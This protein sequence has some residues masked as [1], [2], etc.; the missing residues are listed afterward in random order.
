MTKISDGDLAALEEA[1]P[2]LRFAAERVKNL[3][4]DLPLAIAEARAVAGSDGWSPK[5]RKDFGV[6]LRS[7]AI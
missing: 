2:L 5:F 3:D 4:P 1:G 7:C 6:R